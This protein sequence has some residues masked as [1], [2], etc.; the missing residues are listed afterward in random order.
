ME[1]YIPTPQVFDDDA[2]FRAIARL[3]RV[4]EL[5]ELE[6]MPAD[7]GHGVSPVGIG[8]EIETTWRQLFP[9]IAEQWPTPMDLDT[10]S[11]D[12][13][14]FSAAYNKRDREITPKLAA[15]RPYI[16]R[17][18]YDA[19]WEFSFL[20]TKNV[21]VTVAEASA[22][23]EAGFLRDGVD[24]AMHMTVAGIDND[25]DAFAFLCDLELS[26]GTTPDRIM[27]AAR[28]VKGSWARKGEGGILTRRPEELLGEET[29]GYEFRTLAAR[30]REQLESTLFRAANLAN[31]MSRPDEWKNYR[32]MTEATLSAHGLP[33]TAWDH[34]KREPETWLA[35][36]ELLV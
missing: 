28:S 15:V 11:R 3:R 8:I 35:Y 25:R 18:G 4:L 34:P 31:I 1:H 5:P 20:P 27:E 24:Y 26:G 30:S 21:A 14:D 33:L 17:V 12:F 32:R 9:E 29:T 19:Y 36:S 2:R 6:E 13:R 23:Y 22:L 16:P 7:N 10:R